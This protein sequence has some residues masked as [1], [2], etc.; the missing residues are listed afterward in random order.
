MWE[1]FDEKNIHVFLES[2]E[3]LRETYGFMSAQ[4]Q[5]S[6]IELLREEVHPGTIYGA[7]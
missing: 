1:C 6:L 7:I 3:E 2:V 5:H 4:L